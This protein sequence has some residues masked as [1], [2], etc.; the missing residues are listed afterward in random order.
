MAVIQWIK[1]L[2]ATEFSILFFILVGISV[3][4]F[5]FWMKKI[6]RARIIED[7]PK[8]NIGSAHQGYVELMGNAEFIKNG[9]IISPVSGRECVWYHYII[10]EK[11]SHRNRN[12]I[13]GSLEN[14][15]LEDGET[16][17]N[18]EWVKVEEK[19]SDDLFYIKDDSGVC[20]VDPDDADVVTY[21]QEKWRGKSHY[22]GHPKPLD[23]FL[24]GKVNFKY[25]ERWIEPDEILYILGNFGT[26]GTGEMARD[27]SEDVKELLA[28][29][30][31]HPNQYLAVYKKDDEGNIL[32]SEWEKVKQEAQRQA[33]KAKLSA[34]AIQETHIIRKPKD[35]LFLISSLSDDELIKLYKGKSLW[36]GITACF[37]LLATFFVLNIRLF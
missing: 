28:L 29:W 21:H 24:P 23:D 18:E 32:L 34:P 6:K 7:T 20:V 10:Y 14:F 17:D 4:S 5:I 22:P 11:T 2:N 27:I 1:Q 30:K 15:F 16:S 35:K 12:S 25:E 3:L 37:G 26:E 36:Y 8:S 19:I 9:K 33:L 31:Q 13:L